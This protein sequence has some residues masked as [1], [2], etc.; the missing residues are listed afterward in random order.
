MLSRRSIRL[1]GLILILFTGLAPRLV[2]LHIAG[3]NPVFEDDR[4]FVGSYE[5]IFPMLRYRVGR[6]EVLSH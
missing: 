1:V 4:E 6:E 5:R 2:V 3:M